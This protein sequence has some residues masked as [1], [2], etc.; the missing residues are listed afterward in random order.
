MAGVNADQLIK[1]VE[2]RE[3]I[4][5]FI[6]DAYIDFKNAVEK[7]KSL[8]KVIQDKT[9][10]PGNF[11]SNLGTWAKKYWL[12]LVFIGVAILLIFKLM[13]PVPGRK[14]SHHKYDSSGRLIY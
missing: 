5:Q 8:N 14:R 7:D 3:K 11:H 6:S 2:T 9:G 12:Y 10:K 1:N 13:D 4:K